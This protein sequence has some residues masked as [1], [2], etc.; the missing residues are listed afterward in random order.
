MSFSNLGCSHV[1]I[2]KVFNYEFVKYSII[3][4]KEKENIT[5]VCRK[6]LRRPFFLH[7]SI[8]SHEAS[9][10]SINELVLLNVI[11]C[12]T[13][14]IRWYI[15]VIQKCNSLALLLVCL[16]IQLEMASTLINLG[17]LVLQHTFYSL[18]RSLSTD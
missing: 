7:I 4:K 10:T 3:S 18:Q 11:V 12:I 2:V 15:N 8:L 17:I 16:T 6:M 1:F 5:I 13:C 9:A 14:H